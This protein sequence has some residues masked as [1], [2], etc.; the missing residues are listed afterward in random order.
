MQKNSYVTGMV[1]SAFTTTGALT[2]KVVKDALRKVD[3]DYAFNNCIYFHFTYV[4]ICQR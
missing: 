2:D 4:S 1:A 3:F